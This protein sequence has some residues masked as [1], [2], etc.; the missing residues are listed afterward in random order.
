MKLRKL[1]L[2]FTGCMLLRTEPAL[3]AED[4]VSAR[5]L[6]GSK[7]GE[8]ATAEMLD[9]AIAIKFIS[10]M[11]LKKGQKLEIRTGC[12]PNGDVCLRVKTRTE[13]KVRV[14][15]WRINTAKFLVA[16][17][18]HG[19]R[20]MEAPEAII[21]YRL[22]KW[23]VTFI[24]QLSQNEILPEVFLNLKQNDAIS[25][26]LLPGDITKVTFAGS[27]YDVSGFGIEPYNKG[28]DHP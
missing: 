10:P 16:K 13:V 27:T 5:V 22:N 24:A 14:L 11:R 6:Q 12:S 4:F 18:A 8:L 28:M 26:N 7:S 3:G 2:L 21:Q 9:G 17:V 20:E 19:P 25:M 23:F 15:L 1:L